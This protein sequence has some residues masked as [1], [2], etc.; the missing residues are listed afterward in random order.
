MTATWAHVLLQIYLL[1]LGF[2]QG[3]TVSYLKPRAPTTFSVQNIVAEGGIE[4][5]SPLLSFRWLLL[6]ICVYICITLHILYIN[7]IY[8]YVHHIQAS[9]HFMGS[10]Q[11]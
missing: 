1:S 5:G 6:Y 10:G 11:L 7:H 3:L 8:Y 9:L 2:H 4:W